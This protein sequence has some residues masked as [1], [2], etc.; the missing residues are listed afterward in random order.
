MILIPNIGTE[1]AELILRSERKDGTY[2]L[3]ESNVK[4]KTNILS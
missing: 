1:K 4:N 3:S 2:I